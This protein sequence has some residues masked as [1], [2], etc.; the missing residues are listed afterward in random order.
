MALFPACNKDENQP[1]DCSDDFTG[2]YYCFQKTHKA[3]NQTDMGWYD[4]YYE[5]YDT[6]EIAEGSNSCSLLIRLDSTLQV[7]VSV[8]DSII[9]NPVTGEKGDEDWNGDDTQVTGRFF[10]NDSIFLYYTR[11][12]SGVHPL[13]EDTYH[14]ERTVTGKI[15][16]FDSL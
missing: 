13:Q 6:I 1:I 4:F 5:S 12:V 8:T 11:I 2:K 3:Y 16:P 14:E 7:D 10:S 15:R 9:S